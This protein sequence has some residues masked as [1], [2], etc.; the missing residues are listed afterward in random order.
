MRKIEE[1]FIKHEGE[2]GRRE[3]VKVGLNAFTVDEEPPVPG[4]FTRISS[5]TSEKV[6]ENFKRFKEKRDQ[7]KVKKAIS[8]LRA[9]A[10]KGENFNLIPGIKESVKANATTAEI[11]GTIREAYGLSYDPF[12]M[13]E[14]PF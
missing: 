1:S 11:L 8:E 7:N 6:I 10:E 12:E 14:S 4:G 5:E 13:I 3:R 2:I 9:D